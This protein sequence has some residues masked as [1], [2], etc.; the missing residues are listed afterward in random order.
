MA[1]VSTVVDQHLKRSITLSFLRFALL[2]DLR[3]LLSGLLSIGRKVQS[4]LET[5]ENKQLAFKMF[6]L[7]RKK[8]PFSTT[9]PTGVI[10]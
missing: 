6:Q 10:T 5:E 3:C 8:I 7:K 2:Q 1:L 9:F 4:P